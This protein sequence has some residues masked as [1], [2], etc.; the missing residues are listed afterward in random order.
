MCRRRPGPAAGCETP[1]RD[2]DTPKPLG[3][4]W[5]LGAVPDR[6]VLRL[7]DLQGLLSVTDNAKREGRSPPIPAKRFVAPSWPPVQF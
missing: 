4:A 6:E 5:T 3:V 7:A 2:E 1:I